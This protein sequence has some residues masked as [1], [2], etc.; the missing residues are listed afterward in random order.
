[1]EGQITIFEY[2]Q[3]KEEIKKKLQETANNFVVIG[4]NLKQIRDTEA[5]KEDGYESIFEFAKA[6]YGLE[7]T[8]TSRFMDINTNYSIDGNSREIRL[9]YAG[10]GWSKLSEMLPLR[11]ED[12]ALITEEHTRDQIREFKAAVREND[13]V[14]VEESA[15][16]LNEAS[17]SSEIAILDDKLQECIVELFRNPE[18]QPALDAVFK[19]FCESNVNTAEIAQELINPTDN[20]TYKKGV[21][22]LFLY[23]ISK[24]VTVKDFRKSKPVNISWIEFVD[25]LY[26]IYS[27]K[28]TDSTKGVWEAYYGPLPKVEEPKKEVKKVPEK[29]VKSSISVAPAQQKQKEK[30]VSKKHEKKED[31]TGTEINTSQHE[32]RPSVV[33]DQDNIHI[34]P[35]TSE[36]DAADSSMEHDDVGRS[37]TGQKEITGSIGQGFSNQEEIKNQTEIIGY[38]NREFN[39]GTLVENMYHFKFFTDR[40]LTHEEKMLISSKGL[41]ALNEVLSEVLGDDANHNMSFS[42]DR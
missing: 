27:E 20:L 30:E 31:K 8:I 2:Q 15:E 7:K 36:M 18:L 5:Y 32:K 3:Y 22:Y 28:M 26:Q 38:G 24:G 13:E 10:F 37:G 41:D 6:E 25:I 1:M 14:A 21:I 42:F 39:N 16:I 40:T 11:E 9:E 12:R 17:E 19:A 33:E 4:Y 35:Q 34:S 23:D 29:P